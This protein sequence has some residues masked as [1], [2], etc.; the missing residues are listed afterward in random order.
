MRAAVIVF[1]LAALALAGCVSAYIP[2]PTP[3]PTRT[4]EGVPV[5]HTVESPITDKP[6][7]TPASDS[8]SLPGNPVEGERLFREFQPAAGI[9]CATCHRTDSDDR[10]IGPGLL[11][12][13]IRAQNRQEGLSAADYVYLSIVDPSAYVVAGYTDLMPKNWGQVFTEQQ[14]KDI[15]AYLLAL[16]A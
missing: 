9:A 6:A 14:L 8:G 12:V 4:A 15:V 13:G 7:P 16:S 2:S 5:S 1:M 11:S 3:R 10:L